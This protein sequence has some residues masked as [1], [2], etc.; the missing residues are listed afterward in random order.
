[1]VNLFADIPAMRPPHGVKS[2][3]DHGDSNGTTLL[4]FSWIFT[5]LAVLMVS[6]RVL[7]RA[8]LKQNYGWGWD[9]SK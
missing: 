5:P 3:F 8:K 1:M 7:T 2:D 6:L 4:A 9:D